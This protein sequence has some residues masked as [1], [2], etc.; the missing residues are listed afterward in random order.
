MDLCII[1]AVG[2]VVGRL[3][4]RIRFPA[5]ML[6]GALLATGF[7][8]AGVG[9]TPTPSFV[10][11][12][13]QTAGGMY[14]GC[15]STREDIAQLRTFYKPVICLT[16][17]LFVA[18]YVQ[19]FALYF[20]GYSDL[21]TS[22]M[23]AVPGGVSDVTLISADMGADASRVLLIHLWR[24]IA[25]I[26]IFPILVKFTTPPMPEDSEEVAAKKRM[27]PPSHNLLRV[28]G[29]F[30]CCSIGAYICDV[31][32]DLPAGCL[33]GA[34]VVAFA[35]NFSGYQMVYPRKMRIGAQLLSGVYVGSL[36]DTSLLFDWKVALL[37][38]A[39]SLVIL[40]INAYVFGYI[41][42]RFCHVPLREGLLMLTPAGASDM[43]LISADIG[44]HSPRLV[45]MHLYRFIIACS[46]F[47]QICYAVVQWL[48]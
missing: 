36:L 20:I 14:I 43:A 22:L 28:A 16:I 8:V 46:I 7:L 19:G 42:Q 30:A 18:N 35:L 21:L 40:I 2:F 5:G 6:I 23:C 13:A 38:L 47:P 11:T 26:G 10:K 12:I 15:S 31:I 17:A 45:L 9:L 39:V 34:M 41:L 44:V 29:M 33:I 4:Q 3:F 32:L 25:G 24:L 1:I 37:A 48:Q 27:P